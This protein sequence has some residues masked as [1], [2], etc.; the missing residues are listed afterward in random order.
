MSK[1]VI[2]KRLHYIFFIVVLI[3]T[4]LCIERLFCFKTEHGIMQAR[5]MYDQPR[6]TIDVVFM[7]SSH[8]H[9]DV[10]TALLWEKYGIASYDY[11]A[12][13]QPLWITY[14]YLKEIC[15]YQTP[16]LV[17]LDLYSPAR[18]KDDYQ[19]SWLN[20]NLAGVRF[21][22]NKLGM[23]YASCEPEHYF[24]YFP[25]IAACH[26][27]Y[28][29]LGNEDVEY[30]FSKSEDRAS[31]KGYTP[32]FIKDP[33][34][35]PELAQSRSGGITIKSEEYLQKIIK[36]TEEK[37]I[38]LFLVVSPYITT[39]E[40]ELVYNRVHE[41]A[42]SYGL[43]FN[44]TNYFYSEM[45]LDFDKD[46]NDESHLNYVGSCKYTDYLGQELKDKFNIPDRRGDKKWESWDRHA[47]EISDKAAE[48][49]LTNRT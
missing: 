48:T 2:N 31:F 6:D 28:D 7:G 33:Q 18:F 35:E 43:E 30:L 26:G 45:E 12:A 13:E 11:S 14:Y 46:F 32:Y 8:I 40:D 20:E 22:L 3:I 17:V 27:R 29:E 5:T 34:E 42:D 15:K 36:Y 38:E 9:C 1:S 21:S 41:I 39:D 23:I 10:N 47:K 16:K 24:D 49:A 19:Y 37:N 44:S 25:S 4:Y